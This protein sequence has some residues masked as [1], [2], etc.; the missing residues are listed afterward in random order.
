MVYPEDHAVVSKGYADLAKAIAEF[1]PVT[2]IVN[3]ADAEQV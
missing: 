1:E 2:V 3:P